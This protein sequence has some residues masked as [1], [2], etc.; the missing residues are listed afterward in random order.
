MATV[1]GGT[2]DNINLTANGQT[3]SDGNL[4]TQTVIQCLYV[5]QEPAR[6]VA[7][8][9]VF[10][11]STQAASNSVNVAGLVPKFTGLNYTN[12]WVFSQSPLAGNMAA[13]GSTVTMVLH[14]GPH[15]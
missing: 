12:S 6:L 5:G 7:V 11:L 14:D 13:I 3:V 9:D 2:G 10:E 1:N 15:P 4:I 8:P